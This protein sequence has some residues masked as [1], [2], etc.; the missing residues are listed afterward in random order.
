MSGTS[1]TDNSGIFNDIEQKVIFTIDINSKSVQKITK[2]IYRCIIQ[3]KKQLNY[4]IIKRI[5]KYER[6]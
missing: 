6:L 2:Q 1:K 4:L 5:N 3:L